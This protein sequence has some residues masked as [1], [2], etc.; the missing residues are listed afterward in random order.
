MLTFWGFFFFITLSLKSP[1][2]RENSRTHMAVGVFKTKTNRNAADFGHQKMKIT[3][4]SDDC[5]L[6]ILRNLPI[7]RLLTIRLVSCRMN[8][9][10]RVLFRSKKSLKLF[11]QLYSCLWADYAVMKLILNET[12]TLSNPRKD[13][14]HFIGPNHPQA[15]S[16]LCD[17]YT[18]LNT[19]TFNFPNQL[20][21][22]PLL[23]SWA[24]SLSSLTLLGAP[25]LITAEIWLAMNKLSKLKQLTLINFEHQQIPDSVPILGQL[26]K[27]AIC[28]YY[29]PDLVML[30]SQLGQGCKALGIESTKF[31]VADL[32]K[33]TAKSPFLKGS[34]EMF[35]LKLSTCPRCRVDL[36]NHIRAEFPKVNKLYINLHPNVEQ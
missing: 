36:R 31:Y 2:T 13:L 29:G 1:Q 25:N 16:F 3:H 34:L 33:L 11:G 19:L 4:L 22:P 14:I 32:I 20:Q 26:N 24:C 9:L 23:S 10:V 18:N 15:I 30:L 7:A 6:A 8:L 12:Q 17:L 28:G 21:L 5:L 27:F 35:L